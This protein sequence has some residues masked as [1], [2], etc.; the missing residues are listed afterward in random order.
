MGLTA[1]CPGTF[2]PVTNGHLD[3]IGRTS[4]DLRHRG[5]RRLGEPLQAAPVRRRGTRVHAGGGLCGHVERLRAAVLGAAGRVREGAGCHVDREGFEGGVRLRVRDPDG[6]DE[7]AARGRRDALHA[8]E[9]EMVVPVVLAR[10][11]GRALRRRRRGPGARPRPQAPRS[12]GWEA[13]PD[14][15][16]RA[17]PAAGGDGPRCQVRC[18]CPRR[19]SSTGTR[20]WTCSE[21]CRRP[22]PRRSSRLAGS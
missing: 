17:P 13:G 14:G 1:L 5:G 20:S 16:R 6:A 21:R 18:P 11:G 4:C 3:I 19:R 15:S 8:Y 7:P 10:E 12:T 2:D 9:P 22:C